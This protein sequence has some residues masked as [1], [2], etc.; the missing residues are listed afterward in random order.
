M[1][2]NEKLVINMQTGN[3]LACCWTGPGGDTCP[4]DGRQMYRLV[5]PE[6][7][8]TITYIFCT[9][10]HLQFHL[11]SHLAFGKLPPGYRNVI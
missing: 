7:E 4:K 3:H 2:R 11:H 8:S 9:E 1:P 10:R 6:G 5:V